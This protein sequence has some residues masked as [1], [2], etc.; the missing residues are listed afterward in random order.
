MV[1]RGGS[2]GFAPEAFKSQCTIGGIFGQKF[3]GHT[4]TEGDVLGF[5]HHAHAAAS[6]FLHDA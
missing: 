4:A 2:A 6:Q 1:Q 3:Q 5:V